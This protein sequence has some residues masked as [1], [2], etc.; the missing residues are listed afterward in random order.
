LPP[1]R[2]VAS[3]KQVVRVHI[4]PRACPFS[5]LLFLTCTLPLFSIPSLLFSLSLLFFS[6]SF[7]WE[8]I[9]R[10]H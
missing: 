4:S 7:V 2:G 1:K 9:Y 6:V 10:V 3:L 8:C 5:Q